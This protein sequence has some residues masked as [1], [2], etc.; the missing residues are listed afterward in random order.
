[1]EH[2]HIINIGEQET[3]YMLHGGIRR[4]TSSDNGKKY[5]H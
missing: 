1:M 4:T 2:F 3:M 5:G